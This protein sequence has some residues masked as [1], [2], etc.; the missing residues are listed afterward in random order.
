MKFF[1]YLLTII[2]IIALVGLFVFKQ[3]NGQA[4]LSTDVLLPN[5]QVISEKINDVTKKI[6]KVFNNGIPEKN[7]TVKVY[8]SKDSNGNWSYS[9]KP[10]VATESEAV[11]FDPKGIVVL[12]AFDVSS[13]DLSHSTTTEKHDNAIPNTVITTPSKVLELYKD[14]NNVQKLMDARQQKLSKAIKESTY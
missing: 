7:S 1:A 14:V 2:S 6:H 11:S 12:P 13:V 8:R 9:D 4:W 5:I 10:N 3:P